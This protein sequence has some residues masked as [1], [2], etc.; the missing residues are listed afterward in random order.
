TPDVFEEAWEELMQIYNVR[1]LKWAQE[2]YEKK[3]KATQT[4]KSAVY[5]VFCKELTYESGHIVTMSE[6]DLYHVDDPTSTYWL[7][8]CVNKDLTYI[9]LYNKLEQIMCCCYAKL[10]SIGV[11]C[12]H[13]FAIVKYEGMMKIPRGCILRRWTIKD[14]AHRKDSDDKTDQDRNEDEGAAVG[15][16]NKVKS[17]PIPVHSYETKGAKG[18]K[19][20]KK[21]AKEG[22]RLWTEFGPSFSFVNLLKQFISK[23]YCSGEAS[24]AKGCYEISIFAKDK[25]VFDWDLKKHF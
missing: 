9:V 2:M 12:R 3:E 7:N 6:E 14:K 20:G 19:K 10:E 13:M 18:K 16:T 17:T 15:H 21:R 24:N 1:E 4:Y 25:T 8:D 22:V 5:E 23:T 11:P